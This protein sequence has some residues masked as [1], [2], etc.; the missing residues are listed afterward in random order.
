[1]TFRKKYDRINGYVTFIHGVMDIE[2][3]IEKT[4]KITG[5]KTLHL[6]KVS[7]T[8]NQHKFL[9]AALT[10]TLMAA[11]VLPA[12]LSGTRTASAQ[13]PAAT[14]KTATAKATSR[15]LM[16]ERRMTSHRLSAMSKKSSR[17]RIW[18]S[19]I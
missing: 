18:L 3:E 17:G 16:T 8:R 9:H 6:K 11:L 13:Q 4:E 14:A 12:G 2:M 7:L 15:P 5:G 10:V 1:M 19:A